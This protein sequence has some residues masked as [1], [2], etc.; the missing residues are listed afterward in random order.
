[1]QL[2]LGTVSKKFLVFTFVEEKQHKREKRISV[3]RNLRATVMQIVKM[4]K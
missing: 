4:L 1:L 3:A 2:N